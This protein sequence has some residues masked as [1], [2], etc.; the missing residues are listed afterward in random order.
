MNNSNQNK[1]INSARILKIAAA[2]LFGLTILLIVVFLLTIFAHGFSFAS[3]SYFGMACILFLLC[4]IISA[5]LLGF[6]DLIESSCK[7]Q[8]YAEQILNCMKSNSDKNIEEN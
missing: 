5:L 4:T 6:A 7:T 1:R 8:V 2:I 3:L